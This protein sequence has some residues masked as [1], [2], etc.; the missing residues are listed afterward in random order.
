[1]KLNEEDEKIKSDYRIQ[2]LLNAL[3]EG[4]LDME[5]VREKIKK[6]LGHEVEIVKGHDGKYKII[7]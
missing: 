2:E 1:M 7:L 3:D 4:I 6:I 5:F